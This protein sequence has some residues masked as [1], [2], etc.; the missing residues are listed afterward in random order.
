METCQNLW[1]NS[2]GLWVRDLVP[3]V[4]SHEFNRECTTVNSEVKIVGIVHAAPSPATVKK[5]PMCGINTLR[6]EV[7]LSRVRESGEIC[8]RKGVPKANTLMVAASSS[9]TSWLGGSSCSSSYSENG[10]PATRSAKFGGVNPS[11]YRMPKSR[12]IL[13]IAVI[14]F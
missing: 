9:M 11:T 7:L 13:S 6:G 8:G 10:A 12:R 1:L 4:Q 14:G 5:L 2:L 3:G